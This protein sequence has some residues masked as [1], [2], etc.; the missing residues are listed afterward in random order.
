MDLYTRLNK[1]D[2]GNTNSSYPLLWLLVYPSNG[3]LE[4]VISASMWSLPFC[5]WCGVTT[6]TG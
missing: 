6:G 4:D 5:V 1:H 3:V 2:T